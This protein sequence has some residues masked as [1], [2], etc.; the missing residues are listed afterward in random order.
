[1]YT[2]TDER[3]MRILLAEDEP[4]VR[5]FLVR[6]IER[7]APGYEVEAAPD[8]GAALAAFRR[9]PADLVIS[10][11]HMP[12]LTG[13]ELLRAIRAF[14]AVPFVLISAD[15]TV[16]DAARTAGCSGFIGKPLSLYELRA[17]IV[18]LAPA[19]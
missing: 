2:L 19:R 9:A 12:R 14:S 11:Q 3:I 8:G 4:D 16:A 18:D 17:A 1:M 10:D 13:L 15:T 6:A 5:A 7:A